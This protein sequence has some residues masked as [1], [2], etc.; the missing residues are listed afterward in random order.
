MEYPWWFGAGGSVTGRDEMISALGANAHP[1]AFTTF[2]GRDAT[3]FSE[4]WTGESGRFGLYAHSPAPF[5]VL[6]DDGV[7][8]GEATTAAGEALGRVIIDVVMAEPEVAGLHWRRANGDELVIAATGETGDSEVEWYAAS[9]FSGAH[10]HFSC[11]TDPDEAWP[12]A[13]EMVLR[14]GLIDDTNPDTYTDEN[15]LAAALAIEAWAVR[16]LAGHTAAR[17]RGTAGFLA[18]ADQVV[19]LLD[20][21]HH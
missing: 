7:L 15:D 11:G 16:V 21:R 9:C 6:L 3:W 13:A 10:S 4:A 2:G 17:T 19:D 1:Y 8:E 20:E 12:V 18:G 14:N 5:A